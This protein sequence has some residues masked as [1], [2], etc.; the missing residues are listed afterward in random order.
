[1]AKN[2]APGIAVAIVRGTDTVVMRGWGKAKLDDPI[3]SYRPT[4]P[5]AWHAVTV[6]QLLTHTSGIRSDT[7]VDPDMRIVFT[8][9]GN[10]ATTLTLKQ[11]GGTMEA[12]RK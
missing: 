7:G 6:R 1:M 9:T 2:S 3:G 12:P 8:M 10:N 11:G 5:V 4:L